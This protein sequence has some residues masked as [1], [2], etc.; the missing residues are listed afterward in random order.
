MSYH[1]FKEFFYRNGFVVVPGFITGNEFQELE[2]NLAR[3]IAEVV[4]GLPKT[5]AYYQDP[6]RP[7]TLKQLQRLDRDP[8]FEKISKKAKWYELAEALLGEK[9]DECLGGPEWFNKPPNTEHPT[10]PHQDNYYF[11]FN[12]PLVVTIWVAMEAIDSENGCLRYVPGSHKRGI[13][14]HNRSKVLGF[15]QTVTDWGPAD[16]AA[17]IRVELQAGDAVVH[18]SEL[19]HRAEPNKSS[20][21]HRRAYAQIIKAVGAKVDEKAKAEYEAEVRVHLASSEVR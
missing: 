15:S 7:E 17:E 8:F 5:E 12:P 4:P 20:T 9:C 1:R 2:S 14:P 11:K 10:P 16:E 19:I 21:R 3:Y 6:N 13:R 18:H